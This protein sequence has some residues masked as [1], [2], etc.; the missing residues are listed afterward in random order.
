ML[1]YVGYVMFIV[2]TKDIFRASYLRFI[3]EFESFSINDKCENEYEMLSLSFS[4]M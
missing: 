1:G 3:E 2:N 4:Y